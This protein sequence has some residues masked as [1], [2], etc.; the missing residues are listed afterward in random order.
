MHRCDFIVIYKFTIVNNVSTCCAF[1]F[2]EIY[3][4]T[5][6]KRFIFVKNYDYARKIVEIDG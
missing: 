5:K 4:F 2:V 3:L 6:E 1:T